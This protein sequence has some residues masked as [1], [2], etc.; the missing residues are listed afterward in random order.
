MNALN[1]HIVL[2]LSIHVSSIW[3]QT[4][5]NFDRPVQ[6]VDEMLYPKEFHDFQNQAPLDGVNDGDTIEI[7]WITSVPGIDLEFWCCFSTD[8]YRD[9]YCNGKS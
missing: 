7:D 3:T 8:R 4:T 5:N 6:T 1:L 9:D 2:C